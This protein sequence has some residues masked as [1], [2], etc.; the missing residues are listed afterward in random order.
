V[1]DSYRGINL[2]GGETA[3]G[4]QLVNCKIGLILNETAMR[5]EGNIIQ[6]CE[7]GIELGALNNTLSANTIS[8]CNTGISVIS[9][10]ITG[11]ILYHNNFSGNTVQAVDH[12]SNQWHYNERGNFWSHYSGPDTNLNGIGDTAHSILPNGTDL[13]PLIT[14]QQDWAATAFAGGK[15]VYPQLALGGKS[16]AYECIVVMSNKTNFDWRG[17]LQAYRGN[18]NNWAI[19]WEVDGLNHENSPSREVT[20]PPRGSVKIKLSGGDSVLTGYLVIDAIEGSSD[21]DIAP[22]FFYNFVDNP[23]GQLLDSVGVPPGPSGDEFIL[24]VESSPK[25]NTGLALATAFEDET[26]LITLSLVDL[27]GQEVGLETLTYDGQFARF[28]TEIFDNVPDPFVGRLYVNSEKPIYA[29]G[30]RL[31]NSNGGFQLT[32]IPVDVFI[33]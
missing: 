18:H 15:I 7:Y 30:I 19:D 31:E 23:S 26:F 32:S 6:G 20:L 22:S 33:F 5:V 24:P 17:T 27:D 16:K 9:G 21:Y 29:V 25:V 1:I 2:N 28:F 3:V 13:Y 4:N 12:G 11:N 14:P 8:D 10:G